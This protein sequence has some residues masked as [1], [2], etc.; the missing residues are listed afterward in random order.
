MLFIMLPAYNEEHSLQD[1]LNRIKEVQDANSDYQVL[2]IDDGSTD[3]TVNIAE[4]YSQTMNIT[5][6]KHGEN[7]GL[8][9]AMRTGFTHLAAVADSSDIIFAMDA[10]NTHDPKILHLM[11]RKITLGAD[12]VIA[13]RYAEGGK[14]VGLKYHRK[15]L[16]RGASLLLKIFFRIEGANDYTC[17]YR[18]YKAAIIKDAITL[19]G[20]TFVTENSFVCMAE[21]LIKLSRLTTNIEE[22]PL[23]LRYDLKESASKMKKLRTIARYLFFI[24]REKLI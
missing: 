6:L 7:R 9:A 11:Q 10:D 21:I 18:A 1:L 8:G 17:G 15:M 5:I 24:L 12:V 22:V 19:Y 20:D 23:I 14:E 3:S 16:S 13:S 2:L 4:R